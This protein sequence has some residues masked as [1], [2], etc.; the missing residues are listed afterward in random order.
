MSILKGVLKEEHRRLKS[1]FQ[2]YSRDITLL[3]KGSIS[4]KKR[5]NREYLYIAYRKEKKV[6][7]EY[8][9]AILSEKAQKIMDLIKKRQD[10]ESKLKMVKVDLKELEKVLHGKRI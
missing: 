8:I 9:G 2:R 7:F 1:L 6:K 5:N 10:I 3:P 4:I